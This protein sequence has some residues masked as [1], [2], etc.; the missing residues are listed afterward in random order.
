MFLIT[1]SRRRS[2]AMSQRV[3]ATRRDVFPHVC[4]VDVVHFPCR[5]FRGARE[6]KFFTHTHQER[7]E[8]VDDLHPL[9]PSQQHLRHPPP[10]GPRVLAVVERTAAGALLDL[11]GQPC[12]N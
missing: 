6:R 10:D 2:K 9:N 4:L 7:A 12:H 5:M 3:D 11:A 1:L 8:L